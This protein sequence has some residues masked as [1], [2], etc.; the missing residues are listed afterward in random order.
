[1]PDT[2]RALVYEQLQKDKYKRHDHPARR[3]RLH[4]YSRRTAATR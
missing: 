4:E 3:G 1:M 2:D